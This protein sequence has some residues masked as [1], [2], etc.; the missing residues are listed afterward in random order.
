MEDTDTDVVVVDGHDLTCPNC[1]TTVPIKI[2]EGSIGRQLS[3]ELGEGDEYAVAAAHVLASILP[4]DAANFVM[5]PVQRKAAQI[6]RRQVRSLEESLL[7]AETKRDERR[8]KAWA[9]LMKQSFAIG[10]GMRVD[11]GHASVEHHRQR[12]TMLEQNRKGIADT[13]QFHLRA[14]ELI[15][16]TPGAQC[17]LDVP[18]SAPAPEF[19]Q[20]EEEA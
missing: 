18:F 8:A 20:H 16:G 3:L 6:R 10:N 11:Y 5:S 4:T 12:I 17:L 7:A 9:R 19:A 14:I 15:S 1:G 13:Q 2:P